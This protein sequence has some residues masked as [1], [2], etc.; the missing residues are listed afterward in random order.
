M[1]FRAIRDFLDS[2]PG[3]RQILILLQ[4][5]GGDTAIL[6]SVESQ[7][8]ESVGKAKAAAAARYQATGFDPGDF[9]ARLGIRAEIANFGPLA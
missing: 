4:T 2:Q 5:G 8:A 7:D 1:R 9:I 6:T 3:C